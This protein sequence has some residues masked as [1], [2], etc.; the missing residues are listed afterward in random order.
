MVCTLPLEN[1]GVTWGTYIIVAHAKERSFLKQ[2]KNCFPSG[3]NL[4]GVPGNGLLR[5]L[6]IVGC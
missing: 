1:Q 5:A 4:M 3:V 6:M 2:Q